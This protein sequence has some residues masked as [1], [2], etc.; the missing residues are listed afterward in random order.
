MKKSE[1]GTKKDV[2]AIATYDVVTA[3]PGPRTLYRASFDLTFHRP[4]PDARLVVDS[5]KARFSGEFEPRNVLT[6]SFSNGENVVVVE[7][8]GP[9]KV[10]RVTLKGGN[11]VGQT[12]DLLR[13]DEDQPAPQPTV[14]A[15]VGK[16]NEADVK[17]EFIDVRFAIAVGKKLTKNH[18]HSVIVEGT[19]TGARLGLLAPDADEPSFFWPAGDTSSDE[20]FAAALQ[21]YLDEHTTEATTTV[22]VVIQSD[23]ECRFLL[24]AFDTAAS[25][26]Q[27]AFA[28]PLLVAS[29]ILDADAL[30][31]KIAAAADPVSA[32]L[33][34]ALGGGA[35]VAGLN[36]V[37]AGAALYDA[38]RFANVTLSSGTEAALASAD[39]LPRLNRL[40]LQDAYPELVAAPSAKR[41]LKFGAASVSDGEIALAVPAGAAVSKATIA[42]QESVRSDRTADGD[43]GTAAA[44]RVG[45]HLDGEGSAAAAV[46]IAEATSATGIALPL[47]ALAAP[48]HV[49]IELQADYYG[50]PSGQPLARG[51]AALGEAGTAAWATVFFDP[52]VVAAGQAWLVLRA[53]TGE[54]V[55]LA[56]PGGTELRV[57]RTDD[58]G[59]T[60]ETVL[61]GLAARFRLFTRSGDTRELPATSL[62]AGATP[63]TGV[64]D[65]DRMTYDLTDAVK[66]ALAAAPGEPVPLTI[67]STVAGTITVYP[68]HVEYVV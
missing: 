57:R 38:Q 22:Q 46:T 4:S 18:V 65:G 17:D 13:L 21:S 12:V 34:Y 37:V 35:L 58:S 19:P 44:Q 59:A 39:D 9:R 43:V 33:K 31:A 8:E 5:A 54:A 29:D 15:E 1:V 67:T 14:T 6:T 3:V 25:Y 52:A 16:G 41:T 20:A 64:T 27:D 26:A 47:L 68:P 48:T 42:T 51:T 45:I 63:V 56:D 11:Y 36:G 7:L 23:Q 2:V 60:G 66:A 40:L 30:A 49:S 24:T 53:A 32:F 55:W 62:I 28:S 10:K 50:T 61:A